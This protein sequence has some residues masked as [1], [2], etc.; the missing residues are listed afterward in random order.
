MHP[1]RSNRIFAC[2]V[3]S[4]FGFGEHALARS[5]SPLAGGISCN[6]HPTTLAGMARPLL[7]DSAVAPAEGPMRDPASATRDRDQVCHSD[8]FRW[9]SWLS[10]S[11]RAPLDWWYR[12]LPR[13]RVRSPSR[14]VTSISSTFCRTATT[15]TSCGTIS[16][17]WHRTPSRAG[18]CNWSSELIRAVIGKLLYCTS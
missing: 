13:R 17:D 16:C 8:R 11:W 6:Q 7:P 15:W 18:F 9:C 1:V 12:R 10:A 4:G 5:A 3:D 14:T 2:V